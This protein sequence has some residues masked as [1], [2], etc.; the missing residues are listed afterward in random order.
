MELLGYFNYE[1]QPGYDENNFLNIENPD[2][3]SRVIFKYD[4]TGDKVIDE[5]MVN[6]YVLLS[7]NLN[8]KTESYYSYHIY[9]VECW[10]T[11]E[12]VALGD[13]EI[14]YNQFGIEK[15]LVNGVENACLEDRY[16]DCFNISPDSYLHILYKKQD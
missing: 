10:N 2:V 16:K 13:V 3:Y 4:I 12:N 8:K 5:S 14:Y 11:H 9:I 1:I 15:I 6:D 7:V